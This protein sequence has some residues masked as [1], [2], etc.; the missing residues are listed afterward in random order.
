M[1][2]TLG[3]AALALALAQSVYG[4][5]AGVVGVRTRRAA[6]VRS[7]AA[8]AYANFLLL[9][10]ANGVMVYALV[11]RDF[12]VSYVAQVGSRSTPLFYTV[13]SLW[14]ALEG[15]ILF[16]GW[17]LA[18]YTAAVV[19]FNRARGGEVVGYAVAVM[20]AVGAF[21]YLLLVGPANPF[22]RV[23]P[24]PA[25][26]P[27]PNP[28]LQNHWLMAVHPPFVYLGYVG[29]TV[30]FAFAVGALLAKR[31]DAGWIQATR[32]W[33][34]FAWICLSVSI[35]AGMWWAYEVLGWGG[36]W[37]WDPVENASFMPWLTATAFL[38][39]VMV[40]ERRGMLKVWS[41]S[42]IVATFLLTVLGTFLTRSGILSS[43]HAFAQGT[44]GYYFLGFI[45]LVLVFSVYLLV[46]RAPELQSEGRLDTVVSRETAFLFN[47]L[48][49]AAFA[50]TVVL[51][52]LF[53][54]AAEAVRGVKVS[55]GAPFF[56]KMTIPLALALIL[57]MG[58]APALPWG[59]V[60]PGAAMRRL[61]LPLAT[62]LAV[63]AVTTLLGVRAPTL[64]LAFALAAFAFVANGREYVGG[65][66][67]RVR[68]HGETPPTA[69]VRLVAANRRRYGG[70]LAHLGV[71]FMTV[72][73]AASSGF[74]TD[75]EGTLRRGE[76]IRISGYEVRFE[77]LWG[78]EEPR[79]FVVGADVTVLR[80]GRAL[81][82]LDPR[83]NYYR[84]QAEPVPTPAVKSGLVD[85]YVNLMAFEA[86]GSSVT[87]SVTVEPLVSWIW[88]GG[89]VIALGALV[90][91]WPGRRRKPAPA[92]ERPRPRRA[93][94]EPRPEPTGVAP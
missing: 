51:G 9:T 21:F 84:T 29:M 38:H 22:A 24:V 49:F 80:D 62:A 47:N 54:L 8:A 18:T 31:L 4:A 74:R 12:S 77:R 45:A 52:T 37:A 72:G 13:I 17:V 89:A 43:V 46:V 94:W 87:L 61:L 40:Q 16:W 36:Y 69:L 86:D 6:L 42:L 91:I 79:R 75:R 7:A 28:L 81:T 92:A 64:V 3:F 59:R 83:L 78:A 60:A 33:T 20:L 63:A 11:A 32:R 66:W 56:N 14:G 39:S 58:V 57:L 23:W 93:R 85:V 2:H 1:I 35:V 68:A 50:F 67:A 55:V 15:S 82:V 90:A 44:I 5:A 70:Y 25:D 26:G 76:A 48:V 19:Y 71:V 27:G 53:P 73:I 88:V 30:P 34:V 10:L 41:L 65:V